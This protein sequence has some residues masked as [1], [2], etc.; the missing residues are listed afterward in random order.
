MATEPDTALTK[1]E[2]AQ[3]SSGGTPPGIWLLVVVLAGLAVYAGYMAFHQRQLHADSEMVRKALASDKER[4]ETELKKSKE[5]HAAAKA[6]TE[7][8]RA[9]TEAAS[10]KVSELETKI[11]TLESKLAEA[12]AGAQE[13]AKKLADAQTA[14]DAARE[15]NAALVS[16]NES[17]K[18]QIA[19]AQKKLDAAVSELT[20]A[21]KEGEETP[22]LSPL[23]EPSY[24]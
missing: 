3:K 4:L 23:P 24:P 16:E 18:N 21:S 5:G 10:A 13:N 6:L 1:S 2:G 7:E 20:G 14:L 22:A 9:A 11:S 15:T 8:S 19:E 17:L 12:L